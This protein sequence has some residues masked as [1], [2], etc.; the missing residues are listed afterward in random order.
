MKPDDLLSFSKQTYGEAKSVDYWNAE[1]HINSG[2]SQGEKEL[3]E[4]L[5]IRRG[6]L[7]ILDLGG[8]REALVFAQMGFEVVGVDYIPAMVEQAVARARSRGFQIQGLVQDKSHL[9]LPRESFDLAVLFAAMYSSV[10][11]RQNRVE[12]LDRIWRSLKPGGYF[13]C[14]FLCIPAA[15]RRGEVLRKLLAYLTLGN[16][17][18]ETG[19][20]IWDEEF[21]HAFSSKEEVESEFIEGGFRVIYLTDL[22]ETGFHGAVLERPA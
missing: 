14:Q 19:D 12:M 5:P 22:R 11:T 3:L 1:K 6:R 15:S 21:L 17:R 8:G 18:Y 4:H 13:L 7:L 2:L 16:F 20:I 10:P 9:E